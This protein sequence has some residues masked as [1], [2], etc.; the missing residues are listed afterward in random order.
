LVVRGSGAPD[1]RLQ[2][3]VGEASAQG[4]TASAVGIDG[5]ED[6]G[7][8]DV[9]L[10]AP[11]VA[12]DRAR[13][14]IDERRRRGRRTI[15]DLDG[16]PA[17][18]ALAEHAGWATAPT[19]ALAEQTRACGIHVIVLPRF[20][21]RTEADALRHARRPS[22]KHAPPRLMIALERHDPVVL[23]AL[24][25]AVLAVLEDDPELVMTLGAPNAQAMPQLRAHER[26]HPSGDHRSDDPVGWR[27]DVWLGAPVPDAGDPRPVIEAGLTGVP[28]VFAA[29]TRGAVDDEV[30]CRG[31]VVD[32]GNTDA[33]LAALRTALTPDDM[34][35]LVLRTELLYGP[36]A[37]AA[38]VQRIVGW[39]AYPQD[40]AR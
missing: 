12:P 27:A 8:A 21:T 25:T 22:A 14:L 11:D 23:A 33:W 28:L 6:L 3:F 26:V 35:M 13:A 20:V 30:L 4:A 1:E 9:A 29:D 16:S 36:K 15:V 37:G 19:S 32:V 39:A 10:L 24:E 40:A 7:E 38:I 34:T 18:L 31:A 2:G 5:A 17:S